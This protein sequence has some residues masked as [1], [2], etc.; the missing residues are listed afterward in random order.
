VGDF[1][2]AVLARTRADLDGEAGI[3]LVAEAIQYPAWTG[4]IGG[5]AGEQR[6]LTEHKSVP[7]LFSQFLRENFIYRRHH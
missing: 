7:F 2:R 3:S 4:N 6:D 1:R 5:K